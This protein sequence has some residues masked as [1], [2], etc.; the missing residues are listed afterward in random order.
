[1]PKS[2][3]LR[4]HRVQQNHLYN[5]SIDCELRFPSKGDNDDAQAVLWPQLDFA[6]TKE[7]GKKALL[8]VLNPRTCET[9]D[10]VMACQN[11]ASIARHAFSGRSL[12]RAPLG[13]GGGSGRVFQ[14]WFVRPRLEGLSSTRGRDKRRTLGCWLPFSVQRKRGSWTVGKV[15]ETQKMQSKTPGKRSLVLNRRQRR[16][17][18]GQQRVRSPHGLLGAFR[19]YKRVA[20]PWE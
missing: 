4:F 3:L 16:A 2:L 1:M 9:A 11:V 13:F 10:V 17:G 7:G 12:S 15:P 5:S 6:N 14:M 8:T 20:A 19:S 18:F